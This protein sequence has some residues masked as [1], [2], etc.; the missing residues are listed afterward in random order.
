MLK[1]PLP[2]HEADRLTALYECK[3][4]DTPSD[5]EYDNLA[6]LA[7]FIC[8]TPIALISLVDRHR[9]WFKAKVGLVASET[10]RN[11]A[12]CAYAILQADEVLVVPNALNDPRFANNPLVTDAPYIRF[13][14]GVPIKTSDG[15][16]LGTLCVIDTVPRELTVDQLNALRTLA[17]QV[18]QQLES[19]RRLFN[20]REVPLL[21][22]SSQ[23]KRLPFLLKVGLG[24]GLV[25]AALLGISL[26]SYR[27]TTHEITDTAAMVDKQ[28]LLDHLIEVRSQ[29]KNTELS[30][31]RY[32]LSG[33]SSDLALSH[34]ALEKVFAHLQ[35]VRQLAA[36]DSTQQPRLQK[37]DRLVLAELAE[38]RAAI[39]LYNTQG[40][41][42][43]LEF[44]NRD[45]GR[46]IMA[47]LLQTLDQLKQ[48]EQAALS[49]WFE[50]EKGGMQSLGTIAL[51]GVGFTVA[52]LGLIFGLV[53]QEITKRHRVEVDLAQERDLITA[54]LNTAGALVIVLDASG[55]IVR[56]NRECERTTGYSFL[57]VKHRCIW[58]VLVPPAARTA[59]QA[60]FTKLQQEQTTTTFASPC[61]TKEGQQRL[62]D[63]SGTV[64]L[65]LTGTIEYVIFTGVDI[66]ERQQAEQQRTVQYAIT[67]V[68]AE[69][70]TL[71][72][73]TPKLLQAL[74][75]SLNWEIGQL[76]QVDAATN[77][78]RFVANC[79]QLPLDHPKL[80]P[81]AHQLTVLPGQGLVGRVW[82]NGKPLWS[83]DVANDTNLIQMQFAQQAEMQQAIGCPL[84]CGQEVLGVITGLNRQ[85]QIADESLLDLLMAIGRQIGQFIERKRAEEAVARHHQRLQLLSDITLRI[86]QSLDINEILSTAV[87][88]V[89]QFLQADRV[90]I[91]RLNSN[92]SNGTVVVES[93]RSPWLPLTGVNISAICC[94]YECWSDYDQTKTQIIDDVEQEPLSPCHKTLLVQ[95][96]IR[97]NL[98]VPILENH[99]LWGWLVAHQCATPR[100]WQPFEI[101]SLT[102]LAN[103]V[104]V[105]LAQTRLLTQEIQQRDRLGQQNQA[106]IEARKA[107]EAATRV[108]SAFLAT[109]SHEIRTPM[110]AVIGLADLLLESNLEPQQRDF[111]ETIRN[112]GDA[113]LTLINEILD[114]SKLEAGEM[115]LEVLDFDLADSVEAVA[116]LLA[117]SAQQK[118]LEIATLI[119]PTVPTQLRGDVTRV[120]QVLTNLAGNAIK[121]TQTGEVV[122]QVSLLSE[123]PTTAT[124]GFAVIDTGIGIPAAAQQKLFRPFTQVNASTPHTYGGTGLG[125]AICRQL[126]ELAGGTIG[127]ESEVGVGSRFWFTLPFAKQ[128]PQTVA[129]AEFSGT[130][131]SHCRLLVVDGNPTNR[132]VIRLQTALW[133]VQ[134]D[135]ASTATVALEKM[136]SQARQGSPF[137][138]AILD[139]QMLEVNGEQ[140]GQQIKADPLLADTHLVLLTSLQQQE[141]AQRLQ[142]QNLAIYLVKPVRRS[143]LYDCLMQVLNHSTNQPQQTANSL[144]QSGRA[145]SPRKNDSLQILLVDDNLINQKVAIN[146]LKSLGYNL[147]D[148]ATSGQE[149]LTLIQ[150]IDYDLIFMDC[151]MPLL[152]GFET[153]RLIRQYQDGGKS[154]II[155]ALTANAMPADRDRCLAAGMN[156]YLSKPVRRE[157]L[158]AKLAIWEAK[159][160]QSTMPCNQN[161][162]EIL[163]QETIAI[164][165]AQVTSDNAGISLPLVD[166]EYLHYICQNNKNL[167]LELLNTLMESVSPHL[168]SLKD[169]IAD[170]N[171][172]GIE[173]EA[174]YIK[175]ACANIG[176]KLLAAIA[177]EL[178]QQAC[179]HNSEIM[180]D[181][182][183]RLEAAFQE[184]Q[185]V[186]SQQTI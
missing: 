16:A 59:I 9:Q 96:Q 130:N 176:M 62:I 44:V 147:I 137:D 128:S 152:D 112:S 61:L 64:L 123:D 19:R 134:V 27:S 100:C 8:G 48:A 11:L 143:R 47:E 85:Q 105:A 58:D 160:T 117:I 110:N 164:V 37:I 138:I 54:V 148:T 25:S 17:R 132:K 172:S 36:H 20:W 1:P 79:Q 166:W 140:L 65:T 53:H 171:L 106:L 23:P 12:F 52:M 183:S 157:D 40:Q 145:Q 184:F 22:R 87:A 177:D 113:L 167:E 72:E 175:G 186:V 10:S 126:V 170:C 169:Q 88:E 91:Y 30:R 102:Q 142:A 129:D 109:M 73:A 122:I 154:S 185:A 161:T 103:Q 57:E 4:L 139:L 29:L 156:D 60:S 50:R 101:E 45:A 149:V 90:L 66:T 46:Q 178:E 69:S 86:R 153:T 15:Y 125:L 133:G 14:A 97:A 146:Q 111:V 136:R 28:T 34:Q 94:E 118:G 163:N 13:Y 181:A 5:P 98:A 74:C 76:W 33:N 21:R 95:L 179:L 180:P 119:D 150:T 107:A 168:D 165:P 35:P 84:L 80:E 127:L 2:S 55:Q 99:Q 131:L 68:L 42:A 135:E 124:I 77:L 51:G 39:D 82:Q 18:A 121:F 75:D 7:A 89:R 70:T 49:E 151:Q 144:P 43:A 162:A 92:R 83:S 115:E 141:I 116:A 32:V 104:G 158:A 3:I 56:F 114:F 24:L 182:Y 155:I 38:T 173:Y 174:H 31:Y 93:V 108:K 81:L 26:F 120:R 41:T 71:A 67:R 159:I 6:R 78:I 63:W